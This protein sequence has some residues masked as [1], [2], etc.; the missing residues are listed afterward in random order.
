MNPFALAMV[1]SAGAAFIVSQGLFVALVDRYLADRARGEALRMRNHIAELETTQRALQNASKNLTVALGKAA[2]ASK[3]KSE[4]LASMSHEL[5]TPLNAVIG[6]SESMM[7]EVFGPIGER[8]KDYAADIHNSGAHLLALINDVLD[9]SRLDAGRAELHEEVFDTA[10]L[11][12][13]STRMVLNQAQRGGIALSTD[14]APGLPALKADKRRI[15]QILVN[16][17]SN[18]VK[19][20]PAGGQVKI[21][22]QL[23]EAGLALGVTDSGI[24]IAPQDIAKVLEAFGQIDS[25]LSRKHEGTGLGLPLSKQ[26]VELHGGTLVLESKVNVGTTVTV[27]LP[28]ARLVAR[29]MAA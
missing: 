17:M 27:T 4:F 6:F 16:L 29:E 20:T 18:A 25:A 19:F 1:V 24:G 14:I 5:R 13:E 23:T 2:E 9:L 10:E 12:A 26:L 15:K 3:A 28:P 22:A 7:L 8:Y 21:S 11:I